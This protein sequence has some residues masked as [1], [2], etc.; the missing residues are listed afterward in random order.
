MINYLLLQP[1]PQASNLTTSL[2]GIIVLP[3]IIG[4][5][6]YLTYG[7]DKNRIQKFITKQGGKF[8]SKTWAPF[9]KG[10]FGDKS[11]RIYKVLY[12][13]NDGNRRQAFVKTSIFSGVYFTEDKII[14]AAPRQKSNKND[15][16]DL[17]AEN[18]SLKQEIA[19]LKAQ[20][21]KYKA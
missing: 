1:P 16:A 3:I 14:E 20:Q 15:I 5:I 2:I 9:G 11:N 18:N 10:W 4:L 19:R 21:N 6:I 7:L 12:I 13:D 8:L 17:E